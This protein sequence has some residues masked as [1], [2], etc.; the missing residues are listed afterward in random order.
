MSVAARVRARCDVTDALEAVSVQPGIEE[1]ERTL[2]SCSQVQSG[3][4]EVAGEPQVSTTRNGKPTGDMESG[5]T[6]H[7]DQ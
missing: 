7:I 6:Y 2:V 1:A 4:K 3:R 5:A